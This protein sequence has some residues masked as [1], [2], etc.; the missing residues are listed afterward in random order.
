[1][2]K[3]HPLYKDTNDLTDKGWEA[4]RHMLDRDMPQPRK[5]R[6][7]FGWWFA[8]TVLVSGAIG[9]FLMDKST[10]QPVTAQQAL[11]MQNALTKTPVAGVMDVEMGSNSAAPGSA[12]SASSNLPVYSTVRS[13]ISAIGV[14]N[15]IKFQR[16]EKYNTTIQEYKEANNT[17]VNFGNQVSEENTVQLIDVNPPSGSIITV[18]EP[19]NNSTENIVTTQILSTPSPS[20]VS[21]NA[22]VDMPVLYDPRK[23]R[24]IVKPRRGK[25]DINWG[26][27]AAL[28]VG[29]VPA[30]PGLGFGVVMDALP[31]HDRAGLRLGLLYR[32]QRLSPDNRPVV[33]LPYENYVDATG[34]AIGEPILPSGWRILAANT[35]VLVPITE[36]HRIE[37]PVLLTFKLSNRFDLHAGSSFSR[38]MALRTA[39]RSLLTYNLHV[40]ES[41]NDRV[42]DQLSQAV[43]G[44]LP[45]WERNWMIGFAYH[46]I[47]RL[48][49]GLYFRHLWMG[50]TSLSDSDEV[51]R[52]CTSCSRV[53]YLE[54]QSGR[55][56]RPESLQLNTTWRF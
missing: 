12:N 25:T 8:A 19:N 7:P 31:R 53:P 1:M 44:Q 52:N 49:V 24:T 54:R 35:S 14:R 27:T 16:S 20:S 26:L 30:L 51:L 45:K 48:E 36:V 41:P 50:K 13:K 5:R 33:P 3:R 39:D 21:S 18:T 46:P 11:P 47:K 40:I 37:I 22:K 32:Y 17:T 15:G 55:S 23:N 28:S 10:R 38:V 2:S 9:A 29:E 42:A 34:N 43:A 6:R 4:M 56:V